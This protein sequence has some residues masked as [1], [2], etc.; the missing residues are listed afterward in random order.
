VRLDKEEPHFIIINLLIDG[1]L[2]EEL[3]AEYLLEE[4][5]TS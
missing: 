5:T 3:T 1:Y 2:L 4:L